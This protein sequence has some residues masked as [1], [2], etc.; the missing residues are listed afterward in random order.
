MVVWNKGHYLE[1][2]SGRRFRVSIPLNRNVVTSSVKY[3]ENKICGN[4]Y[5][6]LR[7]IN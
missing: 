2:S 4:V 6:V 7:V 3:R 5:L 1:L